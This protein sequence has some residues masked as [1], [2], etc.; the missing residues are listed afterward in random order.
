MAQ[1]I[2]GR[3]AKSLQPVETIEAEVTTSRQLRSRKQWI[4]GNIGMKVG[5]C[6]GYFPHN[7]RGQRSRILPLV[8]SG[9]KSDFHNTNKSCNSESDQPFLESAAFTK[10]EHS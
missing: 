9:T 1:S 10:M 8:L 4:A 3:A 7:K 2:T 6:P 5:R